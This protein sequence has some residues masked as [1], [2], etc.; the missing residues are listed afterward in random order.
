MELKVFY[1]MILFFILTSLLTIGVFWG[2]SNTTLLNNT[3]LI[4]DTQDTTTK[5]IASTE[6]NTLPAQNSPIAT[7]APKVLGTATAQDF[8]TDKLYSLINA[9][10]REKNIGLLKAHVLLEQ[11]ASL[12]LADMQNRKY[13]THLDPQGRSSWYLFEQVGY[14]Y[15]RAGENLSFGHNSA[16]QVFTAWQES[17]EHN[18]ELLDPTYE[19]M[20]VAIDCTHYTEGGK[21]SCAVVLH[22]GRQL[23]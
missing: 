15:E 20:G 12:K 18:K 7:T 1:T 16:W 9:Y 17:P 2:V 19:Q 10:R 5:P 23:L 21:S 8:T 11:S 22:L 3:H 14:R 6:E 13:W 4:T